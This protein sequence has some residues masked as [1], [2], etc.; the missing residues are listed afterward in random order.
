MDPPPRPN[1]WSAFGRE[2]RNQVA[3]GALDGAV[4]VWDRADG[5]LRD[6]RWREMLASAWGEL[7]VRARPIHLVFIVREPPSPDTLDFLSAPGAPLERLHLTPLGLRAATAGFEAWS[8]LRRLVAY[9]LLGGEPTIWDRLDP[10]LRLST[11]LIRLLL[12]PGAPLRSFADTRYPLPGRNPERALALVDALA[13]GAREW[14]ELK[15]EARAFRT[16]SELG[17]YVKALR[18]AGLVRARQSLDSGPG[19]RNR[20][21]ALG[22]PLLQSWHALFRPHLA[23]LD[24]GLSPAGIWREHIGPEI[25]GL[26]ARRLPDLLSAYLHRHG[27]ERFLAR[28]RETGALWGGGIEI[29]VAGTLVNGAVVYGSTSWRD[30]GE[31]ALGRLGRAVAETRYGYGR[32]SRIMVLFA[33][34]PVAWK[35]ERSVARQPYALLLGPGDLAGNADRSGE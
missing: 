14:G 31:E 22:A 20:R 2:V 18:E 34:Q 17:P 33:A 32:Q 19:T 4:L 23:D 15:D 9:A 10:Q 26:V 12:E 8:P 30:P 13:R 16:S 7:R 11:N 25:P 3:R 35:V 5:L 24:G 6:P 27:E 1:D 21:Y 29:P 28:A